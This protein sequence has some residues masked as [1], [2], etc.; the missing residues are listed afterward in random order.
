V[1]CRWQD[2]AIERLQDQLTEL[3]AQGGVQRVV[4]A[5]EALARAL[6]YCFS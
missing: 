4:E 6:V 3:R 5:E 1:E 2:G